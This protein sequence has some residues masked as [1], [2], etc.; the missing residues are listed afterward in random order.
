MKCMTWNCHGINNALTVRA[1]RALL[2]IY[3]P[4]CLFFCE[5]KVNKRRKEEVLGA[6]QMDFLHCIPAQGNRGGMAFFWRNG[7]ESNVVSCSRRLIHYTIRKYE[8]KTHCYLTGV[9]G[10][11]Y[12]F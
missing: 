9:H 2:R 4:D 12:Y 11:S 5:T 10:S 1:L 8:V 3:R 6:I 7:F